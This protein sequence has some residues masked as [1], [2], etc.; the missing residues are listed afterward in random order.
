MNIAWPPRQSSPDPCNFQR[1]HGSAPEPAGRETCCSAGLCFPELQTLYCQQGR[2][3]VS[4]R[5]P[6][7]NFSS[8]EDNGKN[9]TTCVVVCV[10]YIRPD[11]MQEGVLSL[12]SSAEQSEAALWICLLNWMLPAFF[13]I[14]CFVSS[15][16]KSM[17]LYLEIHKVTVFHF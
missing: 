10:C 13:A 11:T 14:Y 1:R 4:V 9:P 5:T 16:K 6:S 17:K 15:I 8:G 7:G 12:T 2:E 3:A